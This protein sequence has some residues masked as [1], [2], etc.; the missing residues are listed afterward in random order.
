MTGVKEVRSEDEFRG[1]LRN[2]TGKLVVVDFYA[3]WCGPCMMVKPM[4]ESLSQKYSNVIFLKVDVDKHNAI[5]GKEGVK[6][7]PTFVLYKNNTKLT[8]VVGADIQKVEKLIQEYGDTFQAFVG[9]GKTLGGGDSLAGQVYKN[10][11]AQD[12]PIKPK[13]EQT[14]NKMID[15]SVDELDEEMKKAIEMSIKEQQLKKAKT[16][17]SSSSSTGTSSSTTATTTEEK[18]DENKMTDETTTETSNEGGLTQEQVLEH[19]EKTVDQTVLTELLEM[20]F[21]KLRALKAMINVNQPATRESCIE[22][23]LEH[24]DDEDIDS[25]IQYKIETEEEKEKRRQEQKELLAKKRLEN[26]KKLEEQE[27][28]A[29]IEREKSRRLQGKQTLEAVEKYK[30]EQKKREIEAH[31]KEKLEEK[32]EKMKMKQLLEE[33]KLKRKIER[34]TQEGKTQDVEQYKKELELLQKN[35]LKAYKAGVELLQQ[36]QA[37]TTTTTSSS[38]STTVKQQPTESA[39]RVRLL[40]GNTITAKFKPTDTI[41]MVHAHVAN[42]VNS[43]AFT[44]V[45]PGVPPKTYTGNLLNNTL[46]QE[47]LHPRGQLVCSRTK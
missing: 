15:D 8:S 5:A 43:T 45:S 39:I 42:L 40:D 9:S 37:L 28:Q 47:G 27:K 32:R 6:A 44:L 24:Q 38:S 7:M 17:S 19:L 33:D 10:P 22:W 14:N 35:G 13:E 26:K 18:K 11:W 29:Q 36:Q 1:Y 20:E 46:E 30:E 2:S 31:K 3:T 41:K 23:L 12:R 21:P 25:P 4:F 16:S 34:A